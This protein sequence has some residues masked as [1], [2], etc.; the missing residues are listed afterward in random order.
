MNDIYTSPKAELASTAFNNSGQGKVEFYPPGVEG[1]CWGGFF[2]SWI[3]GIGNKTWIAL[4]ALIPYVGF[5]MAILLGIYGRRWAWQ[6]KRWESVEH[7]VRVQRSWSLWG[8]IFVCGFMTIGILAAIAI[9]FY[10]DY[11]QRATGG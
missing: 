3:W 10:A 4:L 1:W 11:V 2:L 5:V 8:T 6:N 7:F 9:P